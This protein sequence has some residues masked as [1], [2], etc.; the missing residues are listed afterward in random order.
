MLTGLS[1]Y[2]CYGK[3]LKVEFPGIPNLAKHD[4]DKVLSSFVCDVN[5]ADAERP[6]AECERLKDGEFYFE[7]ADENYAGAW[8]GIYADLSGPAGTG[9]IRIARGPE[10]GWKG[11][12]WADFKK[13]FNSDSI[14]KDGIDKIVLLDAASEST[15]IAH[16]IR[17]DQWKLKGESRSLGGALPAFATA[18]GLTLFL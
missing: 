7:L 12:L 11:W 14:P 18:C 9:R 15:S 8:D 1:N 5:G 3:E 10:A 6:K 17:F 13:L 16:A 4:F 2:N